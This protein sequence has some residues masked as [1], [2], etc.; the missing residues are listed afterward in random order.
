MKKTLGTLAGAALALFIL[1]SCGKSPQDE[2]V[3]YMESQSKLTQGTY[4]FKVS[5]K[6][7][8]MASTPDQA[9]NPISSMLNT[10]LKDMSL[11]GTMKAD[12][13][14]DNAFAVDMKVNA[15][16]MEIPFN[17]MG[18]FGKEPKMYFATDMME[19]IMGIASSMTGTDLSQGTDYSKLKGKYI[20]VFAM[21]EAM[22]QAELAKAVK[23]M[24]T[25]QK[26]QEKMNKKYIEFIKGLDKK[27]FT[28]K[29]DVISHTFTEEE[30]KQL[31]KTLSEET[32]TDT[33]DLEALFKDFD[34]LDVKLSVNPKTDKTS[35]TIT[36]APKATELEAAGFKSMKLLFETTMTDKK[37][38]IVLPKKENILT[39]EE[40][41]TF[42]PDTN[43]ETAITPEEYKELKDTLVEYKDSL[44][45]DTKKELLETYKVALTEEQYKEIEAILKK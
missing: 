40:M 15:L 35:A 28:K 20:D 13:K 7:L 24:E 11:T 26:N 22:D 25:A 19:Y 44:D 3:N 16:G 1:T 23:E 18:S 4:D 38:D 6:D 21:D 8:E 29:D 34:K 33:K 43:A 36:M 5:I 27:S 2:F 10:Q 39:K 12:T 32:D 17:M 41:E 31:I 42:F 14:K 9:A 45:D 37:A 30:F